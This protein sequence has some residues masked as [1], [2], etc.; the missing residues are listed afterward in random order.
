MEICKISK[1]TSFIEQLWTT[2]SGYI[3]ILIAKKFQ[4]QN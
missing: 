1:Y 3:R 2:A 4:Y